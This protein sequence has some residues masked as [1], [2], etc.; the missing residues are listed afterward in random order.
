MLVK[1]RVV[2]NLFRNYLVAGPPLD[3]IVARVPS[4]L[5]GVHAVRGL[6][7]LSRSRLHPDDA[8]RAL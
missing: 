5:Q 1:M 4:L 6:R 7:T 3:G 2:N 8:R